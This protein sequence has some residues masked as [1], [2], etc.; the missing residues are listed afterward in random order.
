M[1]KIRINQRRLASIE[2]KQVGPI[3][4][5]ILQK[6]I[7]EGVNR[8]RNEAL[9]EFESHPATK[10]ID[11][12]PEGFNQ[13]GTLGGYGNLF[14]FIGFEESMKPIDPIRAIF[15]KKIDVKAS[16]SNL[17]S[18]KINFTVNIPSKE[19]MFDASPMPWIPGRSWL[20]GIEKGISGLSNYINRMSF[21]SRSGEGVQ[22]KNKIRTG[23]FRNIPYISQ[24]LN[25]FRKNILDNIK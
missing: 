12:G 16:P 15:N 3:V 8:A 19:D 23:R 11:S 20:E 13:S 22:T 7:I 21:S 2:N 18:N 25:S 17:K 24:I 1:R 10:E 9:K 6:K 14:S 4:G 5:N